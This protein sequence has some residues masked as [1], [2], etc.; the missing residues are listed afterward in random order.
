MRRAAFGTS[1][2]AAPLRP[3]SSFRSCWGSARPPRA[4]RRRG[5][6]VVSSGHELPRRAARRR[7]KV[8]RGRRGR[9]RRRAPSL[10]RSSGD[11]RRGDPAANAPGGRVTVQQ[12]LAPDASGVHEVA[13]RSVLRAAGGAV[14]PAASAGPPDRVAE[15]EALLRP[16]RPQPSLRAS[17]GASSRAPP[18]RDSRARRS[19]RRG[20]AK[21][22]AHGGPA[23]SLRVRLSRAPVVT[24][25]GLRARLGGAR[26]V[27][28]VDVDAVVRHAPRPRRRHAGRRRPG[29][30]RPTIGLGATAWREATATASRDDAPLPS[31][32]RAPRRRPP[33]RRRERHRRPARGCAP[34]SRRASASR[35]RAGAR[36][37]ARARATSS[38]RPPRASRRR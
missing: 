21:P 23:R 22:R 32:A 29:D 33:G 28:S 30:A 14:A 7:S 4:P 5:A 9:L 11:D 20:S 16:R 38:S 13:A 2:R 36:G 27:G 18:R 15:A 12:E 37:H 25:G 10:P 3:L 1:R 6:S 26:P 17:P 8:P 35:T 24:D 19:A 34:I 31:S